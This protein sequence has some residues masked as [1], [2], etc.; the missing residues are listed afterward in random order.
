MHV[1]DEKEID[2]LFVFID[3]LVSEPVNKK[4]AAKE[5]VIIP[6]WATP[7]DDKPAKQPQ[8][9]APA[10]RKPD[11]QPE[12]EPP[13]EP[14]VEPPKEPVVEPPKEPVVFPLRPEPVPPKEPVVVLREPVVTPVAPVVAPVAPPPAPVVAPEPAPLAYPVAPQP[15][16]PEVAPRAPLLQPIV[17]PEPRWVP[18]IIEGAP[19]A[20]KTPNSA[21]LPPSDMPIGQRSVLVINVPGTDGDGRPAVRSTMPSSSGDRP[22]VV[23]MP[24]VSQPPRVLEDPRPPWSPAPYGHVTTVPVSPPV[25]QTQEPP[26]QPVKK[27]SPKR[28]RQKKGPV[29]PTVIP[30][31]S[32]PG[33]IYKNHAETNAPKGPQQIPPTLIPVGAPNTQQPPANAPVPTAATPNELPPQDNPAFE[34]SEPSESDD[35]EPEES[36]PA[37][38]TNE[39]LEPSDK[40]SGTESESGDPEEEEE[41]E[42][43][44]N[45]EEE[46]EPEEESEG[47]GEESQPDEA[48]RDL[49]PASVTTYPPGAVPNDGTFTLGQATK[50]SPRGGF[51]ADSHDIDYF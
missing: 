1:A 21:F 27:S 30:V 19:P 4:E 51:R 45:S 17:V 8:E 32:S 42:Y 28:E 18:Q 38:N 46:T 43:E 49:K 33:G 9:A 15:K 11:K 48:A 2:K 16:E 7:E 22:I 12:V 39:E 29:R 24:D 20:S 26:R 23:N 3:K 35:S 10:P 44:T 31:S 14:V 40:E 47:V 34:A 36:Q 50:W 6:Q 25:N 41:D 37:P 5:P 13:K